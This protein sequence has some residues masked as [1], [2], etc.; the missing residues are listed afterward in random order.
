MSSIPLPPIPPSDDQ[1]TN[2]ANPLAEQV[3]Q[4][5]KSEIVGFRLMQEDRFSETGT[6][7]YCGVSRT[8]T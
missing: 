8:R 7:R 4:Q 6:A 1:T 3:Y 5:L 2:R